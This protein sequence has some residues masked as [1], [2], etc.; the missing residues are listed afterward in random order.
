LVAAPN[1]KASIER[2]GLFILHFL[3]VEQLTCN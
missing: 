3:V 2:L 1:L